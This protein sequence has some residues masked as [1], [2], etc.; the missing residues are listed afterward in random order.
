ME[1]KNKNYVM[2]F[3]KIISGVIYIISLLLPY[4]IL[5]EAAWVRYKG[6]RIFQLGVM[7]SSI[8]FLV[9]P[10]IEALK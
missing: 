3:I 7:G 4:G 9:N 1:R 6:L 8:C 10:K 5:Y 2:A